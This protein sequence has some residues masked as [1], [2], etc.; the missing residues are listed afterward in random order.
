M[1][2]LIKNMVAITAFV[3]SASSSAEI[4][5]LDFENIAPYPNSNNV[6]I[7]DYYNGGASS[8]GTSGNNYGVQF[9]S[10]A[11][12]LCLNTNAVICSNT[13]KGGLG[14]PTSQNGALYFPTTNPFMNVLAGFDTGFSFTYSDPNAAG[15][16]L[17]IFDGING[18][19]N[20]LATVILPGTAN[21]ATA[22]PGSSAA[23]C[24]FVEFGIT[25]NGVAK[26]VLF[27]G[28]VNSQVFDDITFGS[29]SVG[30]IGS[31]PEPSALII[32]GLALIAT[33]RRIKM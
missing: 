23:F 31:V 6:L 25:F 21:G 15:S 29:A 7:N 1:K 22:C 2:T 18:T 28:A 17:S 33:R 20:L 10:G 27:G 4:I 9:S 26:S 19:G 32:L 14:V 5:F 12:L 24:P 30:E 11:T 16:F 3:F 8:I 13:S